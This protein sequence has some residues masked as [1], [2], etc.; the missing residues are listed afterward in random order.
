M[1]VDSVY[2]DLCRCCTCDILI[3][4]VCIFKG[5]KKCATG[6]LSSPRSFKSPS[7]ALVS[8][9]HGAAGKR[10]SLSA[11]NSFSI[12]QIKT[13]FLCVFLKC[14]IY[15]LQAQNQKHIFVPHTCGR[16]LYFGKCKV[17]NEEMETV[18]W[19]CIP[20]MCK[21]FSARDDT[22]IS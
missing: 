2:Q 11:W 15:F 3:F 20:V 19:L 21:M 8:D 6:L 9:Q 7:G 5:V 22:V 13:S 14:C 16:K 18:T 4:N 1:L 10:V 17:H 12:I